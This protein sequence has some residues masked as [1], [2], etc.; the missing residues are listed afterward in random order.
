MTSHAKRPRDPLAPDAGSA[1]PSATAGDALDGPFPDSRKP[2]GESWIPADRY[3]G[4]PS[5]R[6][7]H[8]N[9]T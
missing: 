4:R 5:Q 9:E 3:A 8:L 1:A 7:E 6:L 2:A